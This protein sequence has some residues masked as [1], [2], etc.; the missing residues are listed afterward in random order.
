MPRGCGAGDSQRG[1]GRPREDLGA[2]R[3]APPGAGRTLTGVGEDRVNGDGE[4]DLGHPEVE[5]N[6]EAARVGS[7]RCGTG[8]GRISRVEVEGYE[9]PWRRPS[10]EESDRWERG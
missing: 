6:E 10:G 9:I 1:L 2:L 7:C 8:G 5:E 4:G 3:P